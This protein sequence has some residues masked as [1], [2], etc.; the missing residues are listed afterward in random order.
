MKK[1]NAWI[2]GVVFVFIFSRCLLD[3]SPIISFPGTVVPNV[4]CPGDQVTVTWDL[5]RT[6][7]DCARNPDACARD[8]LSVDITGAGMPLN[9]RGAAVTGS[10]NVIVPGPDDAVVTVH[11]FD[12]DQDLGSPRFNINVL[13]PSE[14]LSF[15]GGCQGYCTT[16]GPGW[17]DMAVTFGTSTLSPTVQIKRIRNTTGGGLDI[18]LTVTYADGTTENFELANGAE[19]P[20]LSRRVTRVNGRPTP[21]SMAQFTLGMN[22]AGAGGTTEPIPPRSIA[23]QVV[24]GCP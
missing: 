5:T 13:G 11:A 20:N 21:R 12:T 19:T 24:Y 1:F 3:R 8:P 7:A 9:V 15:T 18:I 2:I 23:L 14:E 10:Q 17:R 4:I 6:N 22:C 16:A